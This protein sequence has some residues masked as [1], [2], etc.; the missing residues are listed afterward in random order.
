M[1]KQELRRRLDVL[2]E[3]YYADRW[4]ETYLALLSKLTD[5]RWLLRLY[6]PTDLFETHVNVAKEIKWILD[7]IEKQES[8]TI[9]NRLKEMVRWK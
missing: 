2:D 5:E 7:T 6:V 8:K 1:N 3:L 9:W 4:E